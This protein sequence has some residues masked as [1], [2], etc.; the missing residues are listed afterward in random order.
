MSADGAQRLHLHPDACWTLL[1]SQRVGRLA[2]VA[3]HWP[4][5]HPVN[6]ALH[7]RV[8]VL[9]LAPG[10][11]L[12]AADHANASL[13]VDQVDPVHEAGWSVLVRGLAEV[14]GPEHDEAL[15]R[16]SAATGLEPWAPGPHEHWV[17]LIPQR[18]TGVRLVPAPLPPAFEQHGYL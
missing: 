3:G 11:V 7:D 15:V 16:A 13:Q 6:Y 8:V 10:L 12:D 9:R 14:L 5:V 18:V 17:R 2:V 1:A 4:V